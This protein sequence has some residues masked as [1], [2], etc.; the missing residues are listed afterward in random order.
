[1]SIA[2][3][4][5][6][7]EL[8]GELAMLIEQ[9]RESVAFVAHRRGN[10]A[11]VIW[12]S[13]GL[14]V[15]NNHVA[16]GEEVGIR[17]YDGREL[18]GRVI[19]RRPER[20]LALVTV[21]ASELPAVSAGDSDRVRPGQ[22]AVAI[23]HPAGYLAAASLGVVVAAGQAVT[24]EGLRTGDLIQTDVRIAP[25]SSGGPLIDVHGD[26]IGITTMVAGRLSLAI[27]S[28]AVTEFVNRSLAPVAWLGIAGTA[29]SL[30]HDDAAA[31]VLIANVE[32]GSPAERAGL[33][34]GDIVISIGERPI[35]DAESLPAAIVRMTPGEPVTLRLLRGGTTRTF[36]IVPAVRS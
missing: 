24:E 34:I 3:L 19:A 9:V 21:E 36:A 6:S 33:F 16:G 12:R 20:D 7:T 10:G 29:I 14:I 5:Q 2:E 35:V 4:Q 22:L 8:G 23:G 30:Q 27:P 26:V 17:L 1:M 13:D 11:G 25:G 18:A 31:G 32:T 15:T 28:N